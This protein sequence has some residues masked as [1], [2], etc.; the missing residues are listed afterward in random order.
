MLLL[1][2]AGCTAVSNAPADNSPA[3]PTGAVPA[4]PTTLPPTPAIG[5]DTPAAVSNSVIIIKNF[6]FSPAQLTV[7]KGTSVT[8]KNEDS[9]PHIIASDSGLPGL[10]SGTL[11]TGNEF[12]FTFDQ[13]G[14]QGYHCQIHP[15]MTG[16][17][18]IV[19]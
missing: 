18:K 16:S 14:D 17:V 13:A 15:S 7:K 9:A 11:A 2:G 12:T 3:R 5:T 19:E 1:A 10:L 4:A 6:A 8:W